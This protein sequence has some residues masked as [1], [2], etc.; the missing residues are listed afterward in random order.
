MTT[1]PTRRAV[2]A[3]SLS[4]PIALILVSS[5]VGAWYLAL[6][7]PVAVLSLFAADALGTLPSRRLSVEVTHPKNLF[8]GKSGEARVEITAE[9]YEGSASFDVLLEQSGEAAPPEINSGVMT[10]GSLSVGIPITPRR[11]GKITLGAVWARWKSPLGFFERVRRYDVNGRVDVVPDVKGAHDE[12]IRFFA[13]DAEYGVKSQRFK[14]DGAEFDDLREYTQGMDNRFIDWKSSAR[15]RKLLC[16]EFRQE[17]NHHVVLGFD[18]GRLMTEPLHGI[19]KIDRVIKAGLSLGWISLRGGDFLGGCG[20]DVRFR[21]FVKPGRGMLY[22]NK[23]QRFAA[24]LSYAPEETNFTLGIA[25]LHSRLKRRSL[26]VLFTE[27]ADTIQAELLI[28][29]LEWMAGKHVVIFVTMRDPMLLKLRNGEPGDFRGAARAVI[30]SDFIREREIVLGRIA[31]M[32]VRCLDVPAS[33]MSSA[34]LNCYLS[35]K[36]NRVL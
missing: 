23:I 34:L 21:N 32:G 25:E 12:A 27:F 3:F 15:H 5:G 1:R 13:R 7:Y 2:L 35:I 22:F 31:K 16:K 6:Y 17:R 4:V 33:G 28:E 24:E 14:G 20:F 8:P 26:V 10:G 36:R 11:R 9:G 18:T 30:A 29:S 19:P